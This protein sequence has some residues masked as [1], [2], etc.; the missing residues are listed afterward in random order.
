MEVN[1]D[2][3]GVVILYGG[4]QGVGWSSNSVCR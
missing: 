2:W 4:E 1:R 3:A